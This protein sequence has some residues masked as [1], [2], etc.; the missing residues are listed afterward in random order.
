MKKGPPKI[1]ERV[2]E[3]PSV[4]HKEMIKKLDI[5]EDHVRRSNYE[6][7]ERSREMPEPEI[8][9]PEVIEEPVLMCAQCPCSDCNCNC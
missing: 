6:N 5:L 4:E 9:E 7:Y 8:P 2:V 1:I 3:T